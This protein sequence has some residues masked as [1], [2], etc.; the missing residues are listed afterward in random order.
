MLRPVRLALIVVAAS[1]ALALATGSS[2][3]T[4]DDCECF[5]CGA[6]IGLTVLDEDGNALNDDWVMAATLDGAPVDDASACDP[7]LRLGNSCAFGVATGVYR[8]VVEA[9][10][11]ATREVAA[12]SAVG[13]GQDCCMGACAD[14][15][16]VVVRMIPE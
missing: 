14:Q 13:S 5:P 10:G 12:R 11:F 4:S 7:G 3:S 15:T 6:A 2:C 8:V 9:P 1:G 16:Q